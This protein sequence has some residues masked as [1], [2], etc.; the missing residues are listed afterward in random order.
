MLIR[1]SLG[2]I[3]IFWVKWSHTRGWLFFSGWLGFVLF[4]CITLV[5]SSFCSLWSKYSPTDNVY[6]P[7]AMH[8]D[9]IPLSCLSVMIWQGICFIRSRRLTRR[10][11]RKS[12]KI[13]LLLCCTHLANK[14]IRGI[15]SQTLDWLFIFSLLLSAILLPKM[16][17]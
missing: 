17:S 6:L 9:P 13:M 14:I 16:L 15:W 3:T 5:L 4:C 10:T 1:Q 12:R 8:P 2:I 7:L 11:L